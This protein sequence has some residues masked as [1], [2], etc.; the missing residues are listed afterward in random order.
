MAVRRRKTSG[1]KGQFNLR[2][3]EQD[4][5]TLRLLVYLAHAPSA[6]ELVSSALT[7]YGF[8]LLREMLCGEGGPAGALPVRVPESRSDGFS[9]LLKTLS[10]KDGM[11][12]RFNGEAARFEFEDGGQ[13]RPADG[14]AVSW[15]QS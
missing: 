8:S 7:E 6:S 9:L 12:Y 10:D 3:T 2:L 15:H 11:P 4:R 5:E 1:S 13:W 14:L